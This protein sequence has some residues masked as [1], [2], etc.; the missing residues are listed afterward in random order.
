M[1][2]ITGFYAA[3]MGVLIVYLAARVALCRRDNQIGIGGDD[4][5]EL[6]VLVRAHG[7]AIEN[8]PIALLLMLLAELN[9]LNGVLLHL[10]GIILVAARLAHAKGFIDA[11]GKGSTARFYGILVTWLLILA[12]AIANIALGWLR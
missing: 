10:S 6:R 1:A 9:G 4:N 2:T 11:R 8:I 7:N 3:L 5:K 12:L